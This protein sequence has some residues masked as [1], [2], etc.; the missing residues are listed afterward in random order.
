MAID[1]N[2]HLDCV[3][4]SHRI[5]N[6]EAL[7]MKH[8]EKRNEVRECLL[9]E[10]G[11]RMY[12]PF[13]SGSYAKNT[14]VNTKFDFDL[15]APFKRNAHNTLKEMFDEVHGLLYEKYKNQAIVRKQKVSIGIEFFKDDDN[16]TVKI[17]I[18]P[19]RE[20]NQDQYT[21]D[22]KLNLYVSNKYGIINEGSERIRTNVN[23]QI[24][25]IRSSSNKT[26]IRKVTRLLKVWRINNGKVIKSFLIELITIK[27]FDKKTISGNNWDILEACMEF[28]RDE[29][30]TIALPDPGNGGNNVSDTLT[31]SEKSIIS[32]DMKYMLERIG[33]NSDNIK[34]Y[35]AINP[36][37]PYEESDNKGTYGVKSAAVT[38][39]PAT[40]FG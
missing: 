2:K 30:K 8:R 29:I 33:E 31:D 37:F 34:T 12:S 15:I 27:A 28:I 36:K 35:F 9:R 5:T 24:D 25:N 22:N 14:A 39:P 18:V 13:D 1:K 6:E 3:L 17:D 32:N 26:D 16:D 38:I 11:S 23:A 10:Y 4:K 21:E 7:L 19:G 40:R 20:L